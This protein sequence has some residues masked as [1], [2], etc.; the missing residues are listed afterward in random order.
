MKD[1]SRNANI[2]MLRIILMLLIIAHHYVSHGIMECTN[3]IVAY[4]VWMEGTLFSRIYS[5][6]FLPGGDIGVGLFFMISGYVLSEKNKVS[7]V[8]VVKTTIFYAWINVIY[9]ICFMLINTSAETTGLI[10]QAKMLVKFSLMPTTGGAWWFVTAYVFLAWMIPFFNV[11]IAG[12][13]KRKYIEFLMLI[14]FFGYAIASLGAPFFDIQLGIFFY[15]MGAYI[16]KFSNVEKINKV[17]VGTM[18]SIL[19]MISAVL[20]YVRIH[21]AVNDNMSKVILLVEEITEF[22]NISIV[23]PLCALAIFYFFIGIRVKSSR[24]IDILAPA[25]FGIYLL[26]D[27][28]LLR[29]VMW[30]EILMVQ[31]K[32]Y[33]SIFF[34][35]LFFITVFVIFAFG[36]C[37]EQVRI[38]LFNHKF[39]N[40]IDRISRYFVEDGKDRAN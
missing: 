28:P 36:V 40:C 38:F 8:K 5:C 2:E 31:E 33:N 19:W 3:S 39:L 11:V 29:G 30:N 22:V 18:A 12:L 14:G 7:I 32:Q 21:L 35:I 34:P 4:R 26:H 1:N 9:L 23:V 20:E 6:I 37:V 15:L 10:E 25:T 13:G 24:V 17:K 16:R 27:S